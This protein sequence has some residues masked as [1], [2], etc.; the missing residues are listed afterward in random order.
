MWQFVQ[1]HLSD[2]QI[3]EL[4]VERVPAPSHGIAS[5]PITLTIVLGGSAV[6]ALTRLIG[7]WLDARHLEREME[8]VARGFERDSE[9]GHGL[10]ELAKSHSNVSVA[11]GQPQSLG[12]DPATA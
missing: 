5:E 6:V 1:S 7:Q 11:W 3:D 10:L 2:E 12:P 8:I 9:T 4:E